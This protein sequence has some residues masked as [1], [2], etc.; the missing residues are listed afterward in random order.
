MLDLSKFFFGEQM[1]VVAP[2]ATDSVMADYDAMMNY[3]NQM[4]AVVP[5][6]APLA[7]S[8]AVLPRWEV[9]DRSFSRKPLQ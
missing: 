4:M 1:P 3:T 5:V 8:L 9:K 2:P 7:D 6:S